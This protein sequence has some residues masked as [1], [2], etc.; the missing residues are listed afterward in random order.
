MN[1]TDETDKMTEFEASIQKLA[2]IV[3]RCSREQTTLREIEKQ[4]DEALNEMCAMLREYT[5]AVREMRQKEVEEAK[6]AKNT[7][8]RFLSAKID[9][10]AYSE[11]QHLLME[12]KTDF[13]DGKEEKIED[14]IAKTP[15]LR[16]LD[17]LL[18]ISV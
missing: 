9:P 16:D 7:L 5:I 17:R 3:T 4:A 18:R 15:G 10:K 11:Y 1:T 8:I 13:H 14:L 12:E 2:N 6:A